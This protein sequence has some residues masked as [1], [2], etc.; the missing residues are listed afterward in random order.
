MPFYDEDGNE[1]EGVLSPEEAEELRVKAQEAETLKGQ[2]E[3]MEGKVKALETKDFNFRKFEQ[4]TQ[5]EKDEMLQEFSAKEQ[6]LITEVAEMKSSFM[7]EQRASVLD[8][9]VGNDDELRQKVTEKADSLYGSPA[10]TKEEYTARV[11]EALTL[12][13]SANVVNPLF[14][15]SPQGAYGRTQSPKYTETAEGEANYNKWFK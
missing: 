2:I 11:K 13:K 7:G 15:P 4:A 1:V 3:E 5:K 10:K 8:L 14:S 9:Y 12:I 6:A